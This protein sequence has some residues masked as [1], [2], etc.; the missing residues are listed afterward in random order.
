MSAE[1]LFEDRIK[2]IT[3]S[4]AKENKA[5]SG[6][7]E[8]HDS[9]REDLLASWGAD[10]SYSEEDYDYLPSYIK[11]YVI[12]EFNYEHTKRRR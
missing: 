11:K 2:A 10:E 9:E 12:K 8:L 3:E 4:N 6:W 7:S 1:Q 5:R